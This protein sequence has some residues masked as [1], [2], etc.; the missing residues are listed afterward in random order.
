MTSVEKDFVDFPS[1]QVLFDSSST[2]SITQTQGEEEEPS[3][4]EIKEERPHHAHPLDQVKK[5]N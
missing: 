3:H 2:S 5:K 1:S 4:V